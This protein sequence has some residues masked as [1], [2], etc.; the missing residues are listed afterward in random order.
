VNRDIQGSKEYFERF[1]KKTNFHRDTLEKAYRL[2][3]LLKEINRHPEVKEG[4]VLK[5]VIRM[6][7][8]LYNYPLLEIV[9]PP[10]L[11]GGEEI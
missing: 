7:N 3:D 8:S 11:L 9:A 5:E 4:L 1:S 6:V 2:E 10:E